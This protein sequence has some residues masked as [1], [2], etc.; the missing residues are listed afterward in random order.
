TWYLTPGLHTLVWRYVKNATVNAGSDAAWLDQVAYVERPMAALITTQPT[1]QTAV[2]SSNATFSAVAQGTPPLSYQWLFNGISIPGATNPVFTV[3]NVQLSNLGMYALAVSNNYGGALSRNANLYLFNVCA[4]G[5]GQSNTATP[6]N[7]GQSQVPTNLTGVTAIAAGGYHSLALKSDGRVTGWGYNGFGQVSVSAAFSEVQ[8]VAA[9]FS[10]SVALRSNGTVVAWGYSAYGQTIVPAVATN[11]AA[12]SAGWYHNLALRSNGT[13][14]AWGAGT[15]YQGY[16]PNFG[17]S[18][19][20]TNLAGVA[21][22]AAGGYH[23]LALRTNGTVVA[24]GWNAAGQTNVPVGLT[25]VIAIAAGGSNSIALKG[26]AT[27]VAWGNNTYGQTN[28]PAGLSNVVAVSAGA[29]HC[30]ALKSDGSL[31]AWGLNTNGQTTL[32][33]GLTNV[34]AISAGGYHN[35]VLLN[36]GPVT[37]LS[38]PQ[39]QLVYVGNA[40]TL[41]AACVGAPP[42]AYQ[43]LRDGTNL[44]GAP[45]ASLTLTAA[46]LT[47]TGTYQLVAS[48]VF[49]ALASAPARLTVSDGSPYFVAQPTNQWVLQNSNVTLAAS[50]AG[51]PPLSYQWYLNGAALP[52]ATNTALTITNAQSANAGNYALRVSNAVGAA[53]SSNAALTVIDLGVALNAT[54]LVWTTSTNPPWL[55]EVSVTHDGVAAVSSGL[56]RYTNQSLLQTTVTGPGT[57]SFWWFSTAGGG[58]LYLGFY[59]DG[60][61]QGSAPD[62][63]SWQQ[64]TIYLS[65]GDHALQWRPFWYINSFSYAITGWVDQ[66]TY[67]SGP[68]PALLLSTLASR[69]V[70]AGTNVTFSVTTGGTPPLSLQ[71][72]MNGTNLPGATASSL[73]LTNVQA[74][75]AGIYSLTVSNTYGVTNVSVALTVN[76][77]A[78]WIAVQPTDQR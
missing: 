60:A 7:F 43:W 41:T 47:D 23:S 46:Q 36:S 33:A 14:V 42:L 4:W 72:S 30:L 37:F 71:W 13:V 56:L 31:V 38:Q 75:N 57:L 3:T 67:T 27:V 45:D 6:P 77:S 44:P 65:A 50:A 2:L 8:A 21:A 40:V 66:V 9:G 12:L 54:N 11:V 39:S 64:K 32:P 62:W 26:D 34:I 61:Y 69:T 10:H 1:N 51:F 16:L 76:P 74:A 58:A 63:G 19:V 59:L 78:P 5:A 55:P 25:N 49:G 17:Q 52:G 22:V 28:V 18:V 68:T 35:L 20:P 73:A 48:N 70:P 24:W 29:A 53:T 15:S